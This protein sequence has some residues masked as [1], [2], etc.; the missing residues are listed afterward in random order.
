MN[1]APRRAAALAS[2]RSS[3]V[4]VVCAPIATGTRPSAASTTVSATWTRSSK[5]MVE[6][7]PAAPPARNVP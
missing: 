5:V 6:K 3:S 7:S 4:L 1:S 2:R